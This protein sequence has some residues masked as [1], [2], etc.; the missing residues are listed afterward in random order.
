M[1][2]SDLTAFVSYTVAGLS[3]GAMYA[4]VALGYTIVYGIVRLI[5]FANG[6]LVVLGSF[7]G[8]TALVALIAADLPLPIL[9]IAA[10]VVPMVG[11]ALV[12]LGIFRVAYRPLLR[13]GGVFPIVITALGMSLVLQNLIRVIWGSGY[14]GFPQLLGSDGFEIASV[15][16]TYAQVILVVVAFAVMLA[17]YLWVTR[18][19]MG[20]AMRALAIDHDTARLMGINVDVLIAVA[21]IVGGM[22][23]GVAGAM[24]GLYFIQISFN[25]GFLLG[26][27]AFTAAVLGGIGNV[28]GA[29]VGGLLIGLLEAYSAGYIGS[30]WSDV[31]VFVTLIGVLVLRPRGLLGERVAQGT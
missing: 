25:Q 8:Y 16:V 22:L 2:S 5:N 24:L 13:R 30:R 20:T 6:D 10:F 18:S 3:V 26:M 28:V 19:S 31:V 7:L 23:A 14:Q 21:F 29:M 11:A 12:N 1:S 15:R 27:R 17:L 4:L 9:L